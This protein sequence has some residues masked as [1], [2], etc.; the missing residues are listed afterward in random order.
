MKKIISVILTVALVL[1]AFG[2]VA[3]TVSAATSSAGYEVSVWDG[4]SA[5]GF[6]NGTGTEE[7]PYII[8]D[9]SEL[10]FLATDV[11]S[12]NTYDGMFIKLNVN[13]N[14]NGKG[15]TPIGNNKTNVFKGTFDGNGKTI[16]NLN[17]NAATSGIFGHT[18]TAT[19]K[20][21]NVD[22]AT[23]TVQDRYA[24]AIVG[25][26]RGGKVTGCSVGENVV[27]KSDL[28]MTDTA[29]CGG[30]VGWVGGSEVNPGIVENCTTKAKLEFT[31][32]ND[33]SFVGGVVG[34]VSAFG[35]VKN[36][37]NFGE[38]VVSAE[39]KAG[40]EKTN[41]GGVAGGIGASSGAGILESCINAGTINAKGYVGGVF[42]KIHVADSK[43]NKCFSIGEIT[44]DEGMAGAVGGNVAKL[45]GECAGNLGVAN[46]NVTVAYAK[47]GTDILVS[48]DSFGVESETL[49]KLDEAYVAIENTV[50]TIVTFDEVDPEKDPVPEI[51]TVSDT[52]TEEATTTEKPSDTTEKP[53]ESKTT[54]AEKTETVT[55][56]PVTTNAPED[57]GGCG[58]FTV[59]SAFAFFAAIVGSIAFI[60]VKKY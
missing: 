7:D 13:I 45:P 36:C 34:V 31:Y 60:K 41:I 47:A 11:K 2:T 56:A 57:K 5:P 20:N 49:V 43:V 46:G 9:A 19:I 4:T 48:E 22:Y 10:D 38:I 33:T 17:C 27:I 32:I 53:E 58:S 35:T 25:L 8:N 18:T 30:I 16:Y 21:L 29:Q 14:W 39:N 12:G 1:C 23:F 59:A 42:G 52:T 40:N 54:T 26:L 15:W 50:K 44:A 28:I 3:M 6:V 24:G 37:I 55:K 51:P